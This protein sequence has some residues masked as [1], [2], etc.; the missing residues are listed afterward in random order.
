MGGIEWGFA[1]SMIPSGRRHKRKREDETGEVWDPV[2]ARSSR[3]AG[4]DERAIPTSRQGSG[5]FFHCRDGR[6]R[7]VLRSGDTGG[8]AA[9]GETGYGGRRE[10]D[11]PTS[12][13]AGDGGRRGRHP[14]LEKLLDLVL[15]KARMRSSVYLRSIWLSFS[16]RTPSP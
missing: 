12:G 13:E 4:A 5:L 10:G 16:H 7:S 2:E 8:K 9:A 11:M 15:A 3:R 1:E 14:R 6:R